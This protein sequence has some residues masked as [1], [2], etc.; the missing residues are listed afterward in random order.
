[1]ELLFV[2]LAAH[3]SE[4]RRWIGGVDRRICQTFCASP[5]EPGE[6]LLGFSNG[7]GAV[8]G[9]AAFPGTRFDTRQEAASGPAGCGPLPGATTA[10]FVVCDFEMSMKLFMMPQTVPNRREAEGRRLETSPD[11][12]HLEIKQRKGGHAAALND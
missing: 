5:A 2:C 4:F 10:R 12:P 3:D 8:D 11:H 1:M 9:R 7:R 6:L